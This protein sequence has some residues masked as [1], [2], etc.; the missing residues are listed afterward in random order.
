M[1]GWLAPMRP[2]P[3]AGNGGMHS[4]YAVRAG[5]HGCG[6]GI[7]RALR[8]DAGRRQRAGSGR[9]RRSE[10]L[11]DTHAHIGQEYTDGQRALR[12]GSPHAR[13]L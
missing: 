12:R 13:I 7:C 10:R 6:A 1:K 4:G 3:A 11:R 5:R 8:D 2:L 9:A